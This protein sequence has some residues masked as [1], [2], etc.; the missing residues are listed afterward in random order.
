MILVGDPLTLPQ[1]ERRG[2]AL[3]AAWKIRLGASVKDLRAVSATDVLKAEPNY[4]G[5]I[6]TTFPNLGV[7]I[8][9]Y[10][11]QKKPAEVFATGQEH[12][13]ALLLGNNSRERVPGSTPPQDL[14]KAIEE[15]YGP[16]AARAQ[17]MY[18]GA[19]DPVY[20]TPA[21]QWATD[22]SFRCSAVA[23]LVWHAAAGNPAFEYEF[24]RVPPGREAFGSTHATELSYVFGGLD[25]GIFAPPGPPSRVTAVDTQVSEAMQQHWTN[26]AKTGNPNGGQL[27][28]WPKFDASSRAFIQFTDAGP[29]AKEGLRRPFCDLF[30]E[31]VKRLMAQ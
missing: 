6:S 2:E 17:T 23:Q 3:A 19:A 11:F 28:V 22:T 15:A 31:N 25:R 12:R 24:A 30:I 5:T 13:V 16:I 8:D 20:G 18:V 4:L 7:T 1:A 27:R 21:D 10:V 26:F 14:K 29:I 9:G